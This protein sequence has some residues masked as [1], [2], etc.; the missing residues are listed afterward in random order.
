M[1]NQEKSRQLDLFSG[2]LHAYGQSEDGVLEN[3]QLYA[4]TSQRC[5][6]HAKQSDCRAPVGAAGQLHNLFH[7]KVRWYQQTL[8][9]AGILERLDRGVWGLTT[10]AAKDLNQ[11]KPGISVIGFSTQLGV[12]VLG[13]CDSVFSRIDSPITLILTS[14]PYPLNNPRKY[15]NVSEAQYVDWFCKVIEPVVKNMADGASLCLNISNDIFMPGSPERSMYCERLLLALHDRLG[16][17]LMDRLIWENRSKPPGPI[18]YASKARTQLNVVYEPIYWLTNNPRAVKSD[19]R[20]VLLAHTERHLKLLSQGGEQRRVINSDGAYSIS[21]G[22]YGNPTNGRIARNILNFGHRC[23][24]QSA[25]KKAAKAKG[26][27]V[28]G[29]PMPLKLAQ[30]LIEF[31]TQPGDLVVDPFAGSQTTADAAQRLGRRWLTAEIMAEY[32]L[33]GASRFEHCENYALWLPEK[34]AA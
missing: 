31:L 20:R 8:K 12:A 7:R 24:A 21:P 10:P 5:D 14:P 4:L 9:A 16:L 19:N 2:V 25:Y 23:G 26:L 33:G 6:A 15:G 28:H 32:V 18:Q 22:A 1:S 30:F 34:A 3:T 29:A 17:R 13:A 11:I 27:A